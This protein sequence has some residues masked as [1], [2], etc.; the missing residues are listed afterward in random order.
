[1]ITTSVKQILGTERDVHGDGWKSRRLIL[2]R[3]GLVC[4][5]HETTVRAGFEIRLH[6]QNYRETVYTISGHGTVTDHATGEAHALGPGSLFSS[7]IGDDVTLV[8]ETEM[9]FVCVFEPP[10]EGTEMAD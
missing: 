2:A 10:L 6:H 4:S 9:T 5:I 7:G 3:D 8:A 1:M